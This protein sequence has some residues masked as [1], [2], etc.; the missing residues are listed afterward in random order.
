MDRIGDRSSHFPEWSQTIN[1][2]S[3]FRSNGSEVG[4]VWPRNSFGLW[5][6]AAETCRGTSGAKKGLPRPRGNC[7]TPTPHRR[8]AVE[9]KG[10]KVTP[11]RD[12]SHFGR[13]KMR[14][15]CG[16]EVSIA[17]MSDTFIS[18]WGSALR[19]YCRFEHD[20]PV[21][22]KRVDRLLKLGFITPAGH[23]RE[24]SGCNF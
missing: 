21:S 18:V 8:I 17:I 7:V 24:L 6:T 16:D 22:L 3:C 15:L 23:K 20:E 5:Q 9:P 10:T 12:L 2:L 1:A 4:R 13:D 11:T 14:L 19:V